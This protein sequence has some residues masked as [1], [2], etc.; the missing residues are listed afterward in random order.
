MPDM[1][2]FVRICLSAVAGAS[3]APT[4]GLIRSLSTQL[5]VTHHSLALMVSH[6]RPAT[7]TNP[8]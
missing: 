1:G 2:V 6:A 4:S 3:L 7:D 5:G 8:R